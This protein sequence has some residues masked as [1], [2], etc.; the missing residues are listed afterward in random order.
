M[1]N[2]GLYSAKGYKELEHDRGIAWSA[3]IYRENKKVGEVSNRGC[4]GCDD[5]DLPLE[6]VEALSTIFSNIPFHEHYDT[7]SIENMASVLCD[8]FQILK[9]AKRDLNRKT[10]FLLKSKGKFFTLDHPFLPQVKDFLLN[11]HG[12]D[13]AFFLN[14]A[15]SLHK[16]KT[17]L[18]F[19]T[20]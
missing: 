1:Q 13:I 11:R 19:S 3:N 17:Y 12:D 9:A 5:I 8:N 4:G 7:W 18:Y 15:V 16:S 10:V 20:H 6:H 2:T 14:E